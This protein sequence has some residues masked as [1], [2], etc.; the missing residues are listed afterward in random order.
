MYGR[1][2]R[3][4]VGT[5]RAEIISE[6]LVFQNILRST[7]KEAKTRGKKMQS[8]DVRTIRTI[9]KAQEDLIGRNMNRFKST[10]DALITKI[11]RM[12]GK[13]ADGNRYKRLHSI[14]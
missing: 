8:R 13:Q 1:L 5:T 10:R 2:G 3:S 9:M 6:D 4:G 11:I 7:D 12:E 14:S